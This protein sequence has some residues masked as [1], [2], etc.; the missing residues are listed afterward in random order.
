MCSADGV[1]SFML[2]ACAA[3]ADPSHVGPSK[4]SVYGLTSERETCARQLLGTTA[5]AQKSL[6]RKD[7]G[8]MA[9]DMRKALS[10]VRGSCAEA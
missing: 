3:H 5:E 9:T 6:F 10:K 8:F 1:I 4:N 2:L 7:I